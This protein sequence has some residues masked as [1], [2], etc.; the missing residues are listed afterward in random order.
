MWWNTRR[1]VGIWSL[2]IDIN[3]IIYF[4]LYQNITTV[5][6]VIYSYDFDQMDGIKVF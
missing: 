1:I 5:G 3:F 6:D 2:R 4:H